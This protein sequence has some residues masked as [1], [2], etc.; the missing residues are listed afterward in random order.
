[1]VIIPPPPG[2]DSSRFDDTKWPFGSVAAGEVHPQPHAI[3][4]GKG[5]KFLFTGRTHYKLK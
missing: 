2:G 1:M 3:S 5:K 4:F